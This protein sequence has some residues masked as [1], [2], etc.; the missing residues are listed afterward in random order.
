M[1]NLRVIR[2]SSLITQTMVFLFFEVVYCEMWPSHEGLWISL[3]LN[4]CTSWKVTNLQGS[5]LIT[6]INLKGSSLITKMSGIIF[7]HVKHREHNQFTR[8]LII[9][10]HLNWE[11]PQSSLKRWISFLCLSLK[12]R[13]E[14]KSHTRVLIDHSN[15]GF[16]LRTCHLMDREGPH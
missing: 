4:E 13:G 9:H 5:S 7:E 1:A 8:V 11:G 16:P 10:F 14:F 12:E 3:S 2:G 15:N 6:W